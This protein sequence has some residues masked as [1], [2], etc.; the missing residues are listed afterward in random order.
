M[1]E[2]YCGNSS[3]TYYVFNLL[4]F[5]SLDLFFYIA[6]FVSKYLLY[7]ITSFSSYLIPMCARF[8]DVE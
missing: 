7:S 8:S 2:S 1:K 3:P 5:P 6:L 4:Y